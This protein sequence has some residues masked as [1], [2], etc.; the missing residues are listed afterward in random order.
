MLSSVLS[1]RSRQTDQLQATSRMDST[2]RQRTNEITN[3]AKSINELADLFRDMGDLVVE[4]GTMMDSIEYNL[5]TVGREMR[6]SVE[7]LEIATKY[8]K[9]TGRRKCIFLLVL[10]IIALVVSPFRLSRSW[11]TRA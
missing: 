4:Q 2:I 3:I 9:N 7:E 8:Q 10:I 1:D 5:E 11:P 6:A